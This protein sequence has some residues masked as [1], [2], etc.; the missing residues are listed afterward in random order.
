M[1]WGTSQPLAEEI[2]DAETQREK[3]THEVF[4]RFVRML[5]VEPGNPGN[6]LEQLKGEVIS[7][8][9]FL[10]SVRQYVE[11]IGYAISIKGKRRDNQDTFV[12]GRGRN[13]RIL[14]V[15]DGIGE[16]S[17]SALASRKTAAKLDENREAVALDTAKAVLEINQE[18]CK[19]L[20]FPQLRRRIRTSLCGASTITLALSS[21]NQKLIFR[22]GDSP[23]YL[24]SEEGQSI[25]IKELYKPSELDMVMGVENLD[26]SHI[27]RS[28]EEK[29]RILLASDGVSNYLRDPLES[30]GRAFADNQDAVL[31]AENIIRQVLQRQIETGHA[32]DATLVVEL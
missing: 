6:C 24:I 20:N 8:S 23:A 32:D 26:S 1:S 13:G 10:G 15:C 22:L 30:I 16:Y 29:G 12:I 21:K 18:L 14:A 27:E 3:W 17:L 9:V 5:P 28:C 7:A 4:S 2:E 25:S 31:A 19:V 11:G